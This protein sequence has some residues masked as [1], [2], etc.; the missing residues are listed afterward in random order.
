MT[1]ARPTGTT[2]IT[3]SAVY[4]TGQTGQRPVSPETGPVSSSKARISHQGEEGQDATDVGG[5]NKD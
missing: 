3:S 4:Y 5:S 1:G 2:S